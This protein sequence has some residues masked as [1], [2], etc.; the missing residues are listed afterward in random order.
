[1]KLG[2]SGRASGGDEAGKATDW[3][4]GSWTS[5]KRKSLDGRGFFFFHFVCLLKKPSE[6]L[7]L[8]AAIWSL[9]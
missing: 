3:A 5:R 7:A 8:R 1:M 4:R 6:D 9:I 2:R